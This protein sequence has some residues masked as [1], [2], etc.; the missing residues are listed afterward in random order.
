MCWRQSIRTGSERATGLPRLSVSRRVRAH[1]GMPGRFGEALA[2]RSRTSILANAQKLRDQLEC[3][4]PLVFVLREVLRACGPK[5]KHRARSKGRVGAHLDWRGTRHDGSPR[6]LLVR[7]LSWCG[8]AL[9]P[10][11]TATSMFRFSPARGWFVIASSGHPCSRRG[12]AQMH[13]ATRGIHI[14]RDPGEFALASNGNRAHSRVAP[15]ARSR[16]RRHRGALAVQAAN[17][18][19]ASVAP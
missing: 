19:E 10:E 14:L 12:Y 1:L 6:G 3:E 17:Q 9:A 5:S 4:K 2:Q 18:I 7:N 11:G 13:A 16:R 8:A 15:K